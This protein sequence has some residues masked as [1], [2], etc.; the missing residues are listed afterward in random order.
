[1]GRI[2]FFLLLAIVAYVAWHWMRRAARGEPVARDEST[3]LPQ[4]MVSCAACGL[5]LP[6]QEALV[7][8][9]QFYCCEEHRQRSSGS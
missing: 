9:E 7:A 8:G 4:A 1:M 6:R 5:H 2:F 3:P